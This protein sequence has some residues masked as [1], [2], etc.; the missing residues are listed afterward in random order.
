MGNYF[1]AVVF[2]CDGVLVDSEVLAM[3]V[4]QRVLA[5]LGWQ[6]ELFELIEMFMGCSHEYYVE[7]IEKNLGRVLDDDWSIPYRPWYEKAFAEDLREIEGISDAVDRITLPKAVASNSGHDRIKL[8]LASV[9]LLERFE[10]RICSAEDV[11][12]GKPAPDVYIRA[13]KVLGVSP[14]RC[15]AVEDSK[16][17]V[18]AA[19]SAGMS[20]LAY[21]SDLTPAGWFDRAD[22]T[23][24]RSMADLPGLVHE[25][26]NGPKP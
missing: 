26:S 7:Q 17:G 22:I 19:R 4:G 9:G 15:I 14:E 16:F 25:L 6:V 8:S 11:P 10:G 2:D 18:Q 3:K 24:F 23:V 5:D 21:E 20:V 1:D 12:K 13:A